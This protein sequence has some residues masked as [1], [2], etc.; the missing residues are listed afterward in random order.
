MKNLLKEVGLVNALPNP[1]TQTVS[2]KIT[3]P[4]FKG[5]F[6]DKRISRRAREV[7]IGLLSFTGPDNS[8][9]YPSIKGLAARMKMSRN[10]IKMGL[11]EL[12]EFAYVKT[13]R[14]G[15]TEH[16]YLIDKV[17][18]EVEKEQVVWNSP[19][20]ASPEQ[21]MLKSKE[22]D[23]RIEPTT[24]G[25]QNRSLTVAGFEQATPDKNLRFT[26]PLLSKNAQDFK[27]CEGGPHRNQE[28]SNRAAGAPNRAESKGNE[29]RSKKGRELERLRATFEGNSRSMKQIL[30]DKIFKKAI[31]LRNRSFYDG[32]WD[33]SEDRA[34][35][36]ALKSFLKEQSKN[37]YGADLGSW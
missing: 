10:T 12:I 17:Q 35:Y 1:E 30:L 21:K 20:Q 29:G 16:Y 26:K 22:P 3:L 13:T 37:L 27:S 11:N 7:F 15:Q 4:A 24:N 23:V 5:I 25:L 18:I 8:H 2:V 19:D 14:R 32:A 28:A 6:Q 36:R 31:S 34:E 9:S 33:N